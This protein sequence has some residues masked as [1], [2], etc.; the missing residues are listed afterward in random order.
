MLCRLTP[1]MCLN[2][3]GLIHMDSHVIKTRIFETHYT[4]VMGHMDIIGIIADGFNIYFPMVL[5]LLSLATYFSLGS[6]LLSALGFHQFIGGDDDMTADL[7][8]EGRDLV[9]RG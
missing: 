3:L 5:L 4:Q 1:P 7:V 9:K 8:D 2:F 6:R